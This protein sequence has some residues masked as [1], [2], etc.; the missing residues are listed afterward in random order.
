MIEINKSDTIF[1]IVSTHKEI[2]DLMVELGFKDIIRPGMLKSV[3]RIM[4]VE[5]GC[6]LKKL[7]LK[8]VE[9]AFL[10]AGYKLI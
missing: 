9:D 8:M 6:S 3:G 4:T 7:D 10:E 5:L 1:K 2:I